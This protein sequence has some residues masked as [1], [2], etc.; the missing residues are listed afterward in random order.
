MRT[1]MNTK[2]T[3][4]ALSTV[5]RTKS[6]FLAGARWQLACLSGLLAVV[7]PVVA[8]TKLRLSTL[9]PGTERVQLIN[10]GDFQFQGPLRNG[11]Y[12]FPTGWSRYGDIFVGAGSNM[13]PVNSSV[14]ARGHVDGGSAVSLYQR[15]V[16]LEPN[17]VYYL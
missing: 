16:N 3:R 1:K 11:A 14:V 2:F 6:N 9:R 15:T 12:P 7:T 10:N 8:Q 17:T 13:V 4:A 5:G